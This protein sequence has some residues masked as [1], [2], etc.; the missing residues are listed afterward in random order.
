VFQIQLNKE[1]DV[2]MELLSQSCARAGEI[3][4]G[5]NF[6]VYARDFGAPPIG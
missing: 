6:F 1:A 2:G 3:L 4:S 5:V